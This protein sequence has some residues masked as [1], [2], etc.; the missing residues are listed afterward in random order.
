MIGSSCTWKQ[1]ELDVFQVKVE[2]DVEVKNIMTSER[3]WDFGGMRNVRPLI[4]FVT[5]SLESSWMG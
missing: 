4:L 1:D 2:R 3:F 5:G